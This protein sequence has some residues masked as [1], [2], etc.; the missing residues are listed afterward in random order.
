M[1]LVIETSVHSLWRLAIRCQPGGRARG[2]VDRPA[3]T[4]RRAR[5]LPRQGPPIGAYIGERREDTTS[6]L[7]R[8]TRVRLSN[9]VDHRV[10]DAA[11]LQRESRSEQCGGVS[12]LPSIG[13]M[14]WLERLTSEQLTGFHSDGF[15][16]LGSIAHI[17][18]RAS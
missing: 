11:S 17:S 7:V 15:R 2:R 9:L 3:C 4:N 18:V 8:C 13:H 1:V 5:R 10:G 14:R 16:K 6:V 12:K